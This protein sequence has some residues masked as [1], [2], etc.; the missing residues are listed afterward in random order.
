MLDRLIETIQDIFASGDDIFDIAGADADETIDTLLDALEAQGL[1]LS[2]FSAS[3]IQEAI[4]EAMEQS[5]SSGREIS[6][7]GLTAVEPLADLQVGPTCGFEAI[8][9]FIQ[10][11]NP[12]CTNTVSDYLQRSELFDG[13]GQLV[14]DG[15]AL[16]P[17][18]YQHILGDFGIGTQWHQFSHDGLAQ[19]LSEN[20]GILAVGDAHYLD[21]TTYPSEHSYHAFM[22]TDI[23]RGFLGEITAYKGLDSNFH[24][25]EVH[26]SP[27]AIENALRHSPLRQPLLVSLQEMKWPYKTA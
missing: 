27:K 9:N 21:P 15:I 17:R 14:T 11:G 7:K 19:A 3:D 2:A 25:Q 6:F 1:D 13:G 5:D 24:Q 12:G 22:I 20:R 18:H 4:R 8:E 26:W 23:T 10:L 16:D